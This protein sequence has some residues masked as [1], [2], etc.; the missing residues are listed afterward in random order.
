MQGR[1]MRKEEI[2]DI[3][4]EVPVNRPGGDP[5]LDEDGQIIWD[6]LAYDRRARLDALYAAGGRCRGMKR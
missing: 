3:L 6:C 1:R 2:I 5:V 4:F